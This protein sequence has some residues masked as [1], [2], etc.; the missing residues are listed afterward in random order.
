MTVSP[1]K[2]NAPPTQI[3]IIPSVVAVNLEQTVESDP[4]DRYGPTNLVSNG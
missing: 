4:Y 1:S 2:T 3:G